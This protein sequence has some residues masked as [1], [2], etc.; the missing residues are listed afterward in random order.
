MT[1]ASFPDLDTALAAL[2]LGPFRFRCRVCGHVHVSGS[3]R[4]EACAEAIG[5]RMRLRPVGD[6]MVSWLHDRLQEVRRLY[7]PWLGAPW[8]QLPIYHMWADPELELF[9]A[10]LAVD[11]PAEE[12]DREL[13]TRTKPGRELWLAWAQ[14]EATRRAKEFREAVA[15]ASEILARPGELFEFELGRGLGRRVEYLRPLPANW[16]PVPRHVWFQEASGEVWA[17]NV[18]VAAGLPVPTRRRAAWPSLWDFRYSGNRLFLEVSLP[19]GSREVFSVR[20]ERCGMRVTVARGAAG[21]AWKRPKSGWST[22]IEGK[23]G[24]TFAP[25]FDTGE[26]TSSGIR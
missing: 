13:R 3:Q 15:E 17:Y 5:D 6:F 26:R 4:A 10:S 20:F 22:K 11:A 16:M 25:R 14:A 21:S 9:A 23:E 19:G 1:A 7:A 24:E 18:A 12:I 8:P 2:R